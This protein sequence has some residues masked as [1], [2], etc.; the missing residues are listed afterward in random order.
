MTEYLDIPPENKVVQ[1]YGG[2]ALLI[3]TQADEKRNRCVGVRI[4]T[5]LL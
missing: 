1:A 2:T 5:P 4:S 3:D